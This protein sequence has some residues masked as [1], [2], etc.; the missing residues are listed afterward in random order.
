MGLTLD[1]CETRLSDV[2]PLPWEKPLE[3][4]SS[5]SPHS[6]RPARETVRL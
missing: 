3:K 4:V 1:S 5:N 6:Q 2:S